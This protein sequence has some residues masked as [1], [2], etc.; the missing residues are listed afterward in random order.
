MD[1]ID[2]V[3]QKVQDGGGRDHPRQVAYVEQWRDRRHEHD[4]SGKVELVV[5]GVVVERR[6]HV[7]SRR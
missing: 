4:L 7:Q 2:E 5:V 3:A 1:H 6:R